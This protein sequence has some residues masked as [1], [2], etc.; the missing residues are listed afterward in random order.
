MPAPRLKT[1]Q[2]APQDH[3]AV[4]DELSAGLN[5]HAAV[6]NCAGVPDASSQDAALLFGANAVVPAVLARAVSRLR[7]APRL[8]HV[9][10]AVV[11]GRM[12]VLDES[13]QTDAFSAYAAS[14]AEGERLALAELH[15]GL[16]I[17]RPPSVHAAD[18]RVTRTISRIARSPLRSVA[19]PVGRPSPQALLDNVAAAIA[20]L[21]TCPGTPPAVVIHPW[22]GV[23][24]MSLMESLGGSRP[25][26]VPEKLARVAVRLLSLAGALVPRLA[27]DARR[28]EMLWFG[29]GQAP[30]WLTEGGWVPPHG[31]QAWVDLGHEVSATSH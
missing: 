20:F 10:S 9:S 22:E 7:P 6:I 31:S 28:V 29:Q 12:P 16:V 1:T 2:Y 24:T 21:A 17:Y 11:Q 23:T 30:S 4:V 18:R 14:K 19:G 13:M 8:V 26:M 15:E 3:E 27:P 5:G 25:Y